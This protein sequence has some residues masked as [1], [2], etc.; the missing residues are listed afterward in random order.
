VS[1]T[2]RLNLTQHISSRAEVPLGDLLR[3]LWRRQRVILCVV[4]ITTV[5]AVAI[6]LLRDKTYTATAVVMIQP[7][8]DR[9]V[10]LQQVAQG[11]SATPRD[12]ETEIKFISSH[13]NLARAVDRL[14][15][16]DNPS[17]IFPEPESGAIASVLSGNRPIAGAA[18]GGSQPDAKQDAN[19]FRESAIAALGGG[20]EVLQSGDSNIL[21]ISFTSTDPGRAAL[22]AD[23]IAK[24]YVDSQLDQKL[25]ETEHAKSWLADQVENLR[26]HVM[27]S[28]RTIEQFRAAH[29]LTASGTGQLDGQLIA[30]LTTEL[31]DAHAERTSK[32]SALHQVHQLRDKGDYQLLASVLSSPMIMNLREQELDLLRSEAELSGVYGEQH[33]RIHEL[34]AEKA[35]VTE[36]TQREIDNAIHGL[37]NEVVAARSR[38]DAFQQSL[39]EAKTQSALSGPAEVQLRELEREADANRTLYESFLVRVKETELQQQLIQPDARVVSPAGV[40]QA[41]SSRSV[42]FFALIGFTGSLFIGSSLAM[43]LDQMDSALRTRRQV[44]ELLGVKALGLVPAV[45]DADPNLSGYLG[46]KPGSAYAE[47]VRTVYTQLRLANAAAPPKVVLVTSALP[48]EGKTS[49]AISL[50]M[51]AAQLRQRTLLIDLD[52]RQPAVGDR[53]G[54]QLEVGVLE[55]IADETYDFGDVVQ[56]IPDSGVDVLAVAQGHRSPVPYLASDRLRLLLEAARGHYDCIIVDTP[57]VLGVADVKVLARFVDVV[58]FVIRWQHTKRDAAQ[59]ALKELADVSATIAGAALNNV[60]MRRHAYYAYGDAGQYYSKY[61]SYYYD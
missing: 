61:K 3:V 12:L 9:I 55:L 4:V 6:G 37:E 59:T 22:L 39:K 53:L 29:D 26:Q 5:V 52:L 33:P 31:I 20:L 46:S 25:A 14:D 43:V 23:G 51:C 13:E 15:L 34:E 18:E 2:D 54:M 7:Q 27:D 44:E 47:G 17:L 11:L 19:A 48:G 58:L 10:N 36:R 30:A 35:R 38:E 56:T 49:L 50:A 24:A 42:L 45:Q 40:P 57:P 21:T 60:D 28:E 1:V 41:P 8:E 16:K 32:E